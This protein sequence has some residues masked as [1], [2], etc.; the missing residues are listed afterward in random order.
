[1]TSSLGTQGIEAPVAAV[2][3]QPAPLVVDL[4]HNEKLLA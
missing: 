1:M 3:R 4:L 2:L